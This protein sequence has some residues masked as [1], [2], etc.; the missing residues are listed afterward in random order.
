MMISKKQ[1]VQI[2]AALKTNPNASAV[3]RQVGGVSHQ[4][5]WEIAKKADIKLRAGRPR[6]AAEKR[7]QIIAALAVNPNA[8]AVAGQVGVSVTA[9]WEIAKKA[10]IKLAEGH[11]AKGSRLPPATHKKIIAALTAN[12]N[13]GAVSRQVGGVSHQTVW[14]IAKKAGIA[15]RARRSG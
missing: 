7:A 4:T 1:R 14:K 15:L 2:I 13:A 12:P 3:A 11:A 8:R 5:V 9:V 10:G 6:V